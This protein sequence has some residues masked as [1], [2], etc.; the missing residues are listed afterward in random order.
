MTLIVFIEKM[1]KLVFVLKGLLKLDELNTDSAR[2]AVGSTSAATVVL[3]LQ[4][5]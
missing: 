3:Q 2:S 4:N 1:H 5:Y